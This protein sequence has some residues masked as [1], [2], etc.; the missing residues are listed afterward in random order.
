[1]K[2]IIIMAQSLDGV[3]AH[4]VDHAANWTSK[5][6]K[7]FFIKETKKG[8]AIIFGRNT[9]KTLGDKPLPNRLNFVMT[10]DENDKKLTKDGL[11][12]FAVK[13]QPAEVIEILKKKGFKKIFVGGGS[14]I[15]SLFFD[16]ELVDELWIT[17]EPKIFGTGLKILTEK[18][19]DVNLKLKSAKKVNNTVLLKY[20]VN[21]G[22]SN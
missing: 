2:T 7:E 9:F 13:K 3:I 20:G 11:L 12:E 10:M 4:D 17:V 16:A 19:R 1:M 14:M 8:G 21:Y 22:N 6:D 15:N 5:E 18:K